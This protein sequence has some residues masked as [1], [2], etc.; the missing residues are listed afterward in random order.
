MCDSRYRPPHPKAHLETGLLDGP[1]G[2]Q[3][4][5]KIKSIRLR[6]Y[7]T[8][9]KYLFLILLLSSCSSVKPVDPEDIEGSLYDRTAGDDEVRIEYR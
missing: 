4:S 9:M 5:N 3:K 6:Y 2:Q 8:I 1:E 7:S